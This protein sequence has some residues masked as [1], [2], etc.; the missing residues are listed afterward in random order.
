MLE[1]IR[2]TVVSTTQ[3]SLHGW[4]VTL[5]RRIEKALS[6]TVSK[7]QAIS[8]RSLIVPKKVALMHGRELRAYFLR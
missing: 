5:T 3:G 2:N 4:V 6:G 7:T 1:S 8:D